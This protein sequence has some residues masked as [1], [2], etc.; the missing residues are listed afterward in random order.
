MELGWYVRLRRRELGL[1]VTA[2]AEKAGMSQSYLSQIETGD[3][4]NPSPE[5]L[6]SL[7]EALEV[8]PRELESLVEMNRGEVKRLRVAVTS[9]R[10]VIIKLP[11]LI[12]DVER[13]VGVMESLLMAGEHVRWATADVVRDSFEQ[14]R[15]VRASADKLG[16]L[17]V[18]LRAMNRELPPA[19][20]RLAS[21]F[22]VPR[23]PEHIEGLIQRV[24]NLGDD[25]LDFLIQTVEGIEK[26]V[27]ACAMSKDR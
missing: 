18:E 7:A 8:S 11:K 22:T 5:S 1:S 27:G 9:S 10:K 3:R 19:L 12:S 4:G 15:S 13:Q 20:E 25:G 2:L 21:T 6:R 24:D 26:L 16:K 17:A 14:E 23:Y